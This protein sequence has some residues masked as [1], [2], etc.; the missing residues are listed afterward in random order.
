MFYSIYLSSKSAGKW[1][2]YLYVEPCSL[3]VYVIFTRF[4]RRRPLCVYFLIGGAMCIIAGSIPSKTGKSSMNSLWWMGTSLMF[5][6]RGVFDI[7][8][9]GLRGFSWTVA[10]VVEIVEE[11]VVV[12][13]EILGNLDHPR[14][15]GHYNYF[16]KQ[17]L[18]NMDHPWSIA[19]SYFTKF[20]TFITLLRQ[21]FHK[22]WATLNP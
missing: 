20:G 5:W 16:V 11:W 9:L 21:Y 2:M 3:I 10:G 22:T 8:H 7:S 13:P 4:G 17:L 19:G 18:G 15:L 12:V 6:D 1:K 14:N